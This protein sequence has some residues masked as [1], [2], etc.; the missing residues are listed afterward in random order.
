MGEYNGVDE[1]ESCSLLQDLES[2]VIWSETDGRVFIKD[3]NEIAS[4]VG[5]AERAVCMAFLAN[6]CLSP[7]SFRGVE[8]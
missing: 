1:C 6:S 7:M 5:G 3:E 2:A 4:R 8:S